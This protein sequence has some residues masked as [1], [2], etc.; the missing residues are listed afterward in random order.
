M[1]WNAGA[2]GLDNMKEGGAC[3][4]DISWVQQCT[5]LPV[6]SGPRQHLPREEEEEVLR[7]DCEFQ[8]GWRLTLSWPGDMGACLA[9]PFPSRPGGEPGA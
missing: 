4:T 9:S 2:L 8:S 5:L 7:T 3:I 1:P 6:A